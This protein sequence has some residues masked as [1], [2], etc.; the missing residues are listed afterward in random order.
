MYN[1]GQNYLCGLAVMNDIKIHFHEI[2]YEHKNAPPQVDGEYFAARN[3]DT[4]EKAMA[5]IEFHNIQSPDELDDKGMHDFLNFTQRE[6]R[7]T[8]SIINMNSE[9]NQECLMVYENDLLH[10]EFDY[11]EEYDEFYHYDG[12]GYEDDC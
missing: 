10:E 6:R 12:D 9:M 2:E 4:I 5:Y 8:G 1:S 3:H 7:L 11:D